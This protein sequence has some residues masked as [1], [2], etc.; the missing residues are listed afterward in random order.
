MEVPQPNRSWGV[1]L[2]DRFCL[3]MIL[4]VVTGIVFILTHR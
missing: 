4:L 1:Y 2:L 3:G